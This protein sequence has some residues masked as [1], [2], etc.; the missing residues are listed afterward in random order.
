M[1]NQG[2][3]NS[4]QES[5]I[6]QLPKM[7]FYHHLKINWKFS[8]NEYTLIER[9]NSN[10]EP[11]IYRFVTPRDQTTQT[12]C[13]IIFGVTHGLSKNLYKQYSVIVIFDGMTHKETLDYC[14]EHASSREIV[15]LLE[16]A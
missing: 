12:I 3:Q 1:A 11:A 8:L 10:H 9:P 6:S 5:T 13:N 16:C 4:S 15:S 2:A 7:V 14:S